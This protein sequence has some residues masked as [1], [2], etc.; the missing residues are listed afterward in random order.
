MASNQRSPACKTGPH[1]EWYT[2]EVLVL[3][4]PALR[5]ASFYGAS[6]IFRFETMLLTIERKRIGLLV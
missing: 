2:E 1:H 5:G 6:V 3:T 4:S